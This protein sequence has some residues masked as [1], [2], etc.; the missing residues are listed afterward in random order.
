MIMFKTNKAFYL[1]SIALGTLLLSACT[2]SVSDVDAQGK[3]VAPVFP[4]ATSAVR[5]EG[6]YVNVAN[7]SQVKPGMTKNQLYELIGVPH[8][9]EGII[10]VKEWDYIFHFTQ[11]DKSVLTCQ[12]KVLFNNDMQASSFYFK[13][14]N[15]LERLQA[16]PTKPVKPPV[17]RTLAA[18]SLFTFGSAV[19][20][21]EGKTQIHQMATELNKSSS[22]LSK[23]V[24][25]GHSD[26]IGHEDKNQA[27]SMARAE[28]VKS[29]LVA[30]GIPAST[31]ETRGMGST[32]PV[33]ICPGKATP[34]VIACLAENRRM[35]IDVVEK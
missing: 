34:A 11:Q 18:A 1:L 8:F 6:S 19:L 10:R 14:D 23:V 28:A 3:T 17:G 30:D 31:I 33:V 26:R 29:L 35:T 4:D 20:S 2:R 16:S 9:K 12:Y 15:C 22:V 13:P 21:P 32:Q 7:L 27:L 24:I 5:P 25:T